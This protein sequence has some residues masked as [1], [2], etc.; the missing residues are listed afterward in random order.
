MVAFASRQIGSKEE[1][2]LKMF[3]RLDLNGD[4]KITADELA[5][6]VGDD[7]NI[8]ELMKEVDQDGDGFID[9]EEFIDAWG[10]IEA[11]D[12]KK[13]TQSTRALLEPVSPRTE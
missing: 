6:A 10:D 2:M 13:N 3:R 8:I 7:Q 9:Y 11:E 4:G 5:N 12:I 1:R